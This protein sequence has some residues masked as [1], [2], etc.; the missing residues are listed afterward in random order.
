MTSNFSNRIVFCFA[1]LILSGS[2]FC[3]SLL[4]PVNAPSLHKDTTAMATTKDSSLTGISRL[5]PDSLSTDSALRLTKK[6]DTLQMIKKQGVQTKST[7]AIDTIS[8][9]LT[10]PYFG[11]GIGWGLGSFPILTQWQNAVPDSVGAILPLNPDTLGF[12]ITE[13]INT[14]NILFP[15]YISYTPFVYSTSSVAFDAS[16]FYIGKSLQATLQKDTFP[17]RVDYRQSMNCYG[18]SAGV[19][20]RRQIDE[21]YFK[22]DKVDQTSFVVGLSV[23]PFCHVSKSESISPVGISDSVVFAA[24]GRLRNFSAWGAGGG[25]RIGIC[26]QKSLSA[27]S[28]MEVS[29]SYIGRYMGEFRTSNGYLQNKDVDPSSDNPDDKV[30]SFSNTV[31]IRLDF[32]F[33][34]KQL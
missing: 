24:S 13:P 4:P 6:P 1:V 28:A 27:S 19:Y 29:L 22:I 20:Y 5:K 10:H 30:S 15:I 16:F 3:Q 12:K 31:E 23:L 26:S 34:K 18:F 7:P 2:S 33:G 25:L 21:R 14:Y 17:E 32:L 9:V 11:V 8:R